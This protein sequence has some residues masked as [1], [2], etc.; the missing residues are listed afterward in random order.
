MK[1]IKRSKCLIISLIFLS[2]YLIFTLSDYYFEKYSSQNSTQTIVITSPE[3]ST[4]SIDAILINAETEDIKCAA[5]IHIKSTDPA[6]NRFLKNVTLNCNTSQQ[7]TY[8]SEDESLVRIVKG[9]PDGVRC[10]A[11]YFGL[12]NGSLFYHG[13]F[14]IL[15]EGIRIDK[16]LLLNNINVSCYDPVYQEIYQNVHHY[17]PREGDQVV[18]PSTP[19]VLILF[20]ES[21]SQLSYYRFMKRT[22][23]VLES[24]GNFQVLKGFVKPLNNS[25]P[26]TMAFLTGKKKVTYDDFDE[27]YFDHLFPYIWDDFKRVNYTTGFLEDLTKIGVFNLKGKRGFRNQHFVDWNPRGFWLQLFK[28]RHLN[29]SD[30]NKSISIWDEINENF[31]NHKNGPNVEI[32]LNQINYFIRKRSEEN[33]KFFLFAFHSRMTHDNFNNFKMIDKYFV[34]FFKKSHPYLNDT[35]IILAGDHGPRHGYSVSTSLGRLEERMNLFTIRIPEAMNEE[36]PHLRMFLNAN[37]HR[38]ISWYDIHQMLLDLTKGH[39]S[40]LETVKS[41]P[42][43]PWGQVAHHDRNCSDAGIDDD[44]CICGSKIS[45]DKSKGDV[46]RASMIFLMFVNRLIGSSPLLKGCQKQTLNSTIDFHYV[47]PPPDVSMAI[48]RAVIK[49]LLQP[50]LIEFVFET[51]RDVSETIKYPRWSID[52]RLHAKY[53]RELSL[54]LHPTCL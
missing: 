23:S 1:L 16:W 12:R 15:S 48:D 5:P 46:R 38:L 34:Q 41:G 45:V 31:C 27:I 4:L 2:T 39:L 17:I 40:P 50:S 25:F 11:T 9:I 33:K 21:L 28:E 29:S 22:K 42:I 14:E 8:L 44:Y 36:F 26:N 32:F 10:Y 35:I 7:L 52:S 13:F 30:P 20:I 37:R 6:V 18:Q 43:S 53:R 19:S 47:I 3:V 49:V 24:Y 51:Y 54:K